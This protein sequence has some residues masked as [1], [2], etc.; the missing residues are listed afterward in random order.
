MG[1][2]VMDIG[3]NECTTD[4][5]CPGTQKCLDSPL[6]QVC[7]CPHGFQITKTGCEGW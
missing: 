7:V 4:D 6:Y 5:T 1:L 3:V 2:C